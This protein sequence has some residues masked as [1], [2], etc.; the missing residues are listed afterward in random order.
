MKELKGFQRITLTSGETKTVSFTITNDLLKHWDA[1]MKFR[2]EPGV[3]E[4]MIG[5]NSNELQKIELAIK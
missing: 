1:D 3:Y 5:R 2:V 4:I